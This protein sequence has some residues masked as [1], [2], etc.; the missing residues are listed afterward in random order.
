MSKVTIQARDAVVDILP[1]Y[2]SIVKLL[3]PLLLYALQQLKTENIPSPVKYQ[4]AE[5][6]LAACKI[7]DLLNRQKIL[8]MVTDILDD[9]APEYLF[10]KAVYQQSV[11]LRLE[12]DYNG[13]ENSIRRFCRQRTSAPPDLAIRQFYKELQPDTMDRR[14]YALCGRLLVS[15][16][17]NLVQA[18]NYDE[19]SEEAELWSIPQFPSLIECRVLPRKSIVVAMVFRLRGRFEDVRDAL[20]NCPVLLYDTHR[21]QVIYGRADA[22]TDL[23]QPHRAH[24]ILKPEIESLRNEARMRKAFRR[25]PVSNIDAH[26]QLCQYEGAKELIQEL[27]VAFDGLNLDVSD[28]LL[29][30]RLLVASARTCQYESRYS[31]ALQGWETV[32]SRVQA[33]RSFKDQGHTYA[34]SHLFYISILGTSIKPRTRLIVQQVY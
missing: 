21:Y 29:H 11:I 26:V 3:L 24:E 23:D 32:I 8:T 31:D 2:T 17:E 25:L 18:E 7:G 22:Y 20:E 15:H 33:Y 12:A 4:I 28:Q 13:S 34:V 5:A 19:A 16:L 1:S 27:K 14:F 10:A 9:G 6:L 30:I